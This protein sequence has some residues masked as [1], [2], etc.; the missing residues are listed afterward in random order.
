MTDPKIRVSFNSAVSL[1]VSIEQ[2][3]IMFTFV[4]DDLLTDWRHCRTNKRM[5]MS[6]LPNTLVIFGSSDQQTTKLLG[7]A[8]A[9]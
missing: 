3:S 4:F 1:K 5:Q 7:L 8:L 6:Q 2:V 9:R